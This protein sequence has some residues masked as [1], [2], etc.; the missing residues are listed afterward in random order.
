MGCPVP[1][2]TTANAQ[3]HKRGRSTLCLMFSPMNATAEIVP[4]DTQAPITPVSEMEAAI[5]ALESA[6][7]ALS[8]LKP[9]ARLELA[10][11]L[12]L[13][14]S[15]PIGKTGLGRP[16]E[17]VWLAAHAASSGFTA[18]ERREFALCANAEAK[19]LGKGLPFRCSDKVAGAS[20]SAT[21]VL[22]SPKMAVF[23]E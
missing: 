5:A 7:A 11:R 8:N 12:A 20:G 2:H 18:S 14:T 10:R 6:Q 21:W 4:A 22:Q 9:L 23:S 13:L 15:S 17:G 19:K 1:L 3:R 16:M